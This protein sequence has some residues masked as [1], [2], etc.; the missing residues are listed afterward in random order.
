MKALK[1]YRLAY[2]F[3]GGGNIIVESTSAEKA[4][5]QAR[6]ILSQIVPKLRP[7]SAKVYKSGTEIIPNDSTET[8]SRTTRYT[9]GGKKFESLDWI[10]PTE[11]E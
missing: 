1:K 2:E 11:I 3:H 4:W 8:T 7:Y 6:E 5:I 9:V 10:T